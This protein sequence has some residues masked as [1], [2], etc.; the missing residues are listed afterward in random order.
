MRKKSPLFASA[1]LTLILF[2]ALFSG[3]TTAPGVS[4][5]PSVKPSASVSPSAS[6]SAS[7]GAS[8]T[9]SDSTTT[10]SI[11]NTAAAFENAI[12]SKGTW[13]I[14]IINDLK[15]DKDLTVDGAFNNTK[16]PPASQRKLA[17]Y[18]QDQ[19]RNVT[20]RYT[21]TAPKM[22]INSPDCA[23]WNG[24]FKGDLYVAAKNFQLIG[25]TVDGNIYFTNADAQSSFK[26]DADSKLTGK[27]A[28][29]TS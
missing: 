12:S 4:P 21:L 13:I 5:S 24:T 20:A 7:A 14:A 2:A 11:V 10:A 17:F 16:T 22:T 9:P 15:I 8:Q 27:Q 26:M 23:I 6:P 29:K 1:A 19:N 28:L 25:A 3:C 18:A